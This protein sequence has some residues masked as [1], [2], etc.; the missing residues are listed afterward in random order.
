[1][2]DFRLEGDE[3]DN[4]LDCVP[5]AEESA[6]VKSPLLALA[7]QYLAALFTDNGIKVSSVVVDTL[8][9]ES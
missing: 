5:A 4:L 1:M 7:Y 3:L 2:D 6:E 9:V 8:E